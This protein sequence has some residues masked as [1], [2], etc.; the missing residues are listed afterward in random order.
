MR[1][2]FLSKSNKTKVSATLKG[3]WDKIPTAENR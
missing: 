2:N 1:Q 3:G